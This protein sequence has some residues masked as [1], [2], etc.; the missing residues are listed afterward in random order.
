MAGGRLGSGQAAWLFE[1]QLSGQ[2]AAAAAP[3]RPQLGLLDLL[4]G[5]LMQQLA[6][7]A[8]QAQEGSNGE[9]PAPQG[10]D[11]HAQAGQQLDGQQQRGQRQQEQQAGGQQQQEAAPELAP[12]VMEAIERELDAIAV[13][14]M[15]ETGQQAPRRAPPASK[16]AVAALPR[17]RLTEARLAEFGGAEARCPVCM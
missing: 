12:D 1:G 10:T 5:N 3:Q 16:K 8:A 7:A 2:G 4:G 13:Q 15:E 9:R 14:I 17:E 11:Q 6:A